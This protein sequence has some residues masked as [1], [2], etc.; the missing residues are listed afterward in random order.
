M[1]LA[2]IL[3]AGLALS[4]PAAGLTRRCVQGRTSTPASSSRPTNAKGG[5]FDSAVPLYGRALQ[6]K[7]DASKPS[8][9]LPSPT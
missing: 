2:P 4:W 9:A 6:A 8:W 5:D 3:I 7:P 1:K